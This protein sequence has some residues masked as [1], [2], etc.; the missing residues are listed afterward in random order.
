MAQPNEAATEMHVIL[1]YGMALL[2]IADGRTGLAHFT[3][4]PEEFCFTIVQWCDTYEEALTLAQL[5]AMDED[6]DTP[7]P[8]ITT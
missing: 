2:T 6:E 8:A 5:N 1:R 4:S 7:L 3:P